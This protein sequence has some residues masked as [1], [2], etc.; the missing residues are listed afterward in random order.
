MSLAIIFSPFPSLRSSSETAGWPQLLNQAKYVLK[1]PNVFPTLLSRS[2]S[3]H[4]AEK[5]HPA[6]DKDKQE[7][8]NWLA[9]LSHYFWNQ[10]PDSV[11]QT[12]LGT[13]RLRRQPEDHTERMLN[14][15]SLTQVIFTWEG[16]TSE[17][18]L[19]PQRYHVCPP[20][21]TACGEASIY[22]PLFPKYLDWHLR[23]GHKRKHHQLMR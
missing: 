11:T 14:L 16:P 17:M 12:D 22:L 13:R 4:G 23:N 6:S 3:F 7:R 8:L 21:C 15:F 5:F 1:F 20:D 9:V 10:G 19:S 2:K 18:A